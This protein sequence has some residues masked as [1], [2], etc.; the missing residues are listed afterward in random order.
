MEMLRETVK[1]QY[2]YLLFYKYS[3]C[4]LLQRMA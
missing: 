1:V 4:D 3:I 2:F